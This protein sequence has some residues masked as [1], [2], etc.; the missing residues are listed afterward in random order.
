VAK[1][2]LAAIVERYEDD[3]ANVDME[4]TGVLFDNEAAAKSFLK[5]IAPEAVHNVAS[6]HAID[7][8]HWVVVFASFDQQ[9]DSGHAAIEARLNRTN[10]PRIEGHRYAYQWDTETDACP[11]YQLAYRDEDIILDSAIDEIG[12]CFGKYMGGMQKT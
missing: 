11:I 4:F 3:S 7:K 8:K 1:R 6:I 9:A 2:P 10:T 12:F 5:E